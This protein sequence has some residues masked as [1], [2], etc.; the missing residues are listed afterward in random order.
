[1]L[2]HGFL[3]L[4]MNYQVDVESKRKK[5]TSSSSYLLYVQRMRPGIAKIK[6]N[7]KK[8]QREI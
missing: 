7:E 8:G 4:H 3:V 5:N 6:K 1:M 2:L